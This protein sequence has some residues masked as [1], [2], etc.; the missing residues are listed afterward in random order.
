MDL[1][2][3]RIKF[4]VTTIPG[5]SYYYN[6]VVV[7]RDVPDVM[8]WEIVTKE[9]AEEIR[10]NL[11]SISQMLQKAGVIDTNSQIALLIENPEINVTSI[12]GAL[13]EY[14]EQEEKDRTL[15]E[16]QAIENA[17]EQAEL[18]RKAEADKLQKAEE[19]KRQK[20]LK[21]L[22]QLKQKYGDTE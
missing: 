3:R 8:D 13:S 19:R 4:I 16:Q 14:K 22:E 18:L 17:K 15:M 1:N 12:L 21:Q 5:Y 7:R 10:V 9:Q 6:T 2:L 11:P 20:E